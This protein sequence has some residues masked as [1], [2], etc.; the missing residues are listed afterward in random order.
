M[1]TQTVLAASGDIMVANALRQAEPD[2]MA[3]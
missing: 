3:A 2:D 1:A